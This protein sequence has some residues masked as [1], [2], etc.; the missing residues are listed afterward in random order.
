[1]LIDAYTGLLP[2]TKPTEDAGQQIVRHNLTGNAS[3]VLQGL[4]QI[5]GH[6]LSRG[7]SFQTRMGLQSEHAAPPE[8]LPHAGHWQ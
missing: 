2:D 3:Q 4:T 8:G 6:Q 7:G 1:M 5:V